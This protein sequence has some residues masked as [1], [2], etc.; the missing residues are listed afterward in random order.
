MNIFLDFRLIVNSEESVIIYGD[1]AFYLLSTRF[2]FNRKIIDFTYV[3][4][5]F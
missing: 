3:E 2:F 4:L 1:I 5:D